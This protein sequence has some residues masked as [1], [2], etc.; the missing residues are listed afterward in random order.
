MSETPGA[1]ATVDTNIAAEQ[2]TTEVQELELTDLESPQDDD[3]AETVEAE[4]K[5][6]TTDEDGD[7]EGDGRT[8]PAKFRELFKEHKDLKKLW[9]VNQ[10]YREHF[11]SPAEAEK[12]KLTIMQL[13]GDEG[14]KAIEADRT[15]LASID[16]R[17]AEGD[18]RF[19]EEIAAQNPEGFA[20]II[21]HALDDLA[22]IDPDGYNHTMSKIFAST[23]QQRGGLAD[24]IYNVQ[25]NL[26]N[27]N[28]QNATQL[29]SQIQDY[30]DGFDK[31]ARQQPTKRNDTDR[32]QFQNEKK[33]WE[34][35]KMANWQK[36]VGSEIVNHIDTG[37]KKELGN[38]LKGKKLTDQAYAM[39]L[40]N[41]HKELV[42]SLKNDA[43]YQS[44]AKLHVTKMDKDAALKLHKSRTDK[45]LP[46]AVKN[47]YKLF[48]SNFGGKTAEQKKRVEV[49]QARK[50]VGS[51]A[52]AVDKLA[53]APN[54]ADIDS[55]LTTKEMILKGE[56]VLK[57]GKKVKF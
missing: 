57:S 51:G 31:V 27:G 49:N 52:P 19:V 8:I 36:E 45:Y 17:L 30:I 7:V 5:A 55:R 24:A 2:P 33:Q 15:A 41:V 46:V 11:A 53:K 50:D 12:A 37:T 42:K 23:F 47:T 32:E 1:V 22:R 48:Y 35:Q 28:T 14:L 25:Q 29:L 43:N 26:A 9:F 3:A 39:F 6:D 10:E 13:G 21:P 20:K 16:Q 40:D 54:P 56:A 44:Q 18:P 4:G 34:Q 38:Y